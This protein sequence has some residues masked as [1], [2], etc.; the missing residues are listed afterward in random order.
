M[1]I[2]KN[3]NKYYETGGEKVHAVRNLSVTFPNTGLAF[4]LGPSGSGKSTLLNL[5]A[6][7][8]AIY[9]SLLIS[10]YL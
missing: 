5:L 4:I 1:I 7:F 2:L 8:A 9:S 3:V 6:G 10:F